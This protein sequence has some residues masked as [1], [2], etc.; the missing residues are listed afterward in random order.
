[1]SKKTILLIFVA[2]V[3]IILAVFLVLFLNSRKPRE[4]PQ[5]GEADQSIPALPAAQI[6]KLPDPSEIRKS[7]QGEIDSVQSKE[8]QISE[9]SYKTASGQLISLDDFASANGIKIKTEVVQNS[10]QKDY[11]TFFCARDTKERPAIGVMFQLRRDVSADKY[12]EL[13]PKMKGDMKNW[14]KTIFNDLAPLFFPDES[15]V[16]ESVFGEVKYTT[17]NKANVIQ[18][19]YANLTAVSGK[20]Y[21]IDWGFLNDQVFISND[22]DCLRR[23]LDKNADAYEP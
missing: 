13:Y 18:I 14:E 5:G 12:K 15:F 1:M 17:S 20:Q 3:I 21:S 9:K 16:G 7:V 22:R 11:I 23:E 8:I 10:S 2:I 19:R 6:A 4:I